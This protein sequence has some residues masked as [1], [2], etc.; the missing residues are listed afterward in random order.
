MSATWSVVRLGDVAEV[1]SGYPF[2]S[3]SWVDAGIPVIKI[4][5]VKNG[6]LEMDGC[7]FVTEDTAEDAQE[8]RTKSG[9][10]LIAMTGY[11]GDVA[12]VRN[13]Q[14]MLVN[15]RV[16][17]FIIKKPELL[18]PRFFFS[19]LRAPSTR[20]ELESR[21]YGSA[22][23]NISPSL[24]HGIEM[25]LPP[26][27]QQRIIA[28]ILGTLDD[29]ID[30]NH[31]MNQTLEATARTIF[32]SW[33]VNFDPVRTKAEGRQPFGMDS[34][35]AALFPDSFEESEI[36][37]IPKGW[38]IAKIEDIAEKV[39]MGPFGSNIKVS[40][41][42]P[43]GIPVISGQHLNSTLLNDSEYNF[44]TSEHAEKLRGA[45]VYRGDVIFTH[46]GSIGQVS[47]IPENSQFD[48]YVLSQRQFYMRSD[49]QKV[50]P[51]FVVLFFKTQQGQHK[52]LANTSSTGV[53]SI[54]RPV[55]YLRSI[56]LVLPQKPVIN[57]FEKF[58]QPIYQQIMNNINQTKNL[59]A[60]R[61]T[62]LP[63][64]MS[65]EIQGNSLLPI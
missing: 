33:F 26:I 23:P 39:A 38:S 8:F 13:N 36:G 50:S 5:N 27:E 32:E 62:L 15:Q 40:T 3:T 14:H 22:Q 29:K 12:L 21:G 46:A 59:I 64:L 53:P 48:R 63:K 24:I 20:R 19:F 56:Q 44:I 10:I 58:V 7:S 4:A 18:D 17:K 31:N 47:L 42:V 49:T 60:L 28:N 30:L 57:A 41:F 55:T 45:N 9:D 34:E 52:L 2:K 54:S 16:G 1:K 61:N 25:P 35:T 51:I 11:V 43:E 6:S 37:Q 65:G